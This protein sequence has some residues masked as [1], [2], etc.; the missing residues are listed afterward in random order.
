M[1][2]GHGGHAS[3]LM[4]HAISRAAMTFPIGTGLGW[5][6]IHPRT[7]CRLGEDTFE[8]LV[9]VIHPCEITGIWP[10]EVDIMVIAL[11]PK[12]DGGLRPIGLMPFLLRIWC[13][14]RKDV[15]AEWERLNQHPLLY[16]GKGIGADIAAW[17]QAARA[18]LAAASTFKVGYRQALLDL[19]KA[20]DRI[21]HWLIVRGP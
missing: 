7:I 20:F 13:R 12:S 3:R 21:P 18:E 14:A 15:T 19:V 5:D 4:V 1:A 6:G 9:E 2:A 8:W 10:M 11:L 17:K 16:F